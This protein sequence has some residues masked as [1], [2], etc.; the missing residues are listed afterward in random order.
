MGQ[1]LFDNRVSLSILFIS[2][3]I[4]AAKY[5][6]ALIQTDAPWVVRELFPEISIASP[7]FDAKKS[8]TGARRISDPFPAEHGLVDPQ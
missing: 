7:G 5:L 8:G 3:S 4:K 2:P 6:Q 1:Y